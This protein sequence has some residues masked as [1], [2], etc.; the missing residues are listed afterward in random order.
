MKHLLLR[1]RSRRCSLEWIVSSGL[2]FLACDKHSNFLI[3]V[4]QFVSI[5]LFIYTLLM[6]PT[7]MSQVQRRRKEWAEHS[8]CR[9]I[10]TCFRSCRL[11]SLGPKYPCPS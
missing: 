4:V 5:H 3:L 9:R 7:F 6:Q 2:G 10:R 11:R 8:R 1:L